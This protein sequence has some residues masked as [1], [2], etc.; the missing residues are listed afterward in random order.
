MKATSQPIQPER[1]FIGIDYHKRYSVFCVINGTGQILERGRIEHHFPGQCAALVKR[2]PKCRV[3]FEAT[4][5]WHWLYELV[6][7]ALPFQDIILANPFKTRV[8]AEAQIKT[9]KIDAHIL[10]QL[11]RADLVCAVHIPSK[12]TRRRKDVLR[13]RCFFVKQRTRLR[14]RVHRLL[15]GQHDLKLPQC[16]DLFG[17]KGMSFLEKL[18][19]PAPAGLLLKQQLEMLKTLQTRSKEDETALDQ[20]VSPSGDQERVLSLPG[21]GPILAAVVVNEIDGIERFT[22]AQKLCGYAGLCPS[23]SSSGGKTYHGKLM[24]QCNKWLRWGFVEASWVAIGCSSYFG[25]LYKLKRAA[26]KKANTAILAVARRMARITWQLLTQKRVYE[27][28]APAPKVRSKPAATE[29]PEATAKDKPRSASA[30]GKQSKAKRNFPSR[31][32]KQLIGR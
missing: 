30:Q 4:M 18:E 32:T 12:E 10:A 15:G 17:K 21:M 22:S 24:R 16:S 31:S 25:D 3:V 29:I 27:T 19:L 5:N 8:I 7:R 26:G 6:E 13:Q 14:N 2:Y 20:M 9:D 23:T 28:V 11:P 1:S